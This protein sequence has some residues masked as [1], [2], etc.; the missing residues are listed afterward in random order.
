MTSVRRGHQ[1][2]GSAGQQHV[3]ELRSSVMKRSVS[4]CSPVV[5]FYAASV[6]H[7]PSLYHHW[8][9]IYIWHSKCFHKHAAEICSSDSKSI[10]K[11]IWDA[12]LL[13]PVRSRSSGVTYSDA[14][15][16]VIHFLDQKLP[17]KP[18]SSGEKEINGMKRKPGEKQ[19]RIGPQAELWGTLPPV[20]SAEDYRLITFQFKQK[21]FYSRK[22]IEA[23]P[24]YSRF[25]N[26]K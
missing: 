21:R 14:P 13:L 9:I 22:K 5:G 7:A 10:L 3:T 24:I 8:I 20:L 6:F 17:R 19:E 11:W 2:M 16:C 25:L 4:V 26:A 1:G 18:A 15:C 12:A 23:E